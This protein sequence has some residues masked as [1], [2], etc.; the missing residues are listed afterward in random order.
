MLKK[1]QSLANFLKKAKLPLKNGEN[2]LNLKKNEKKR[3]LFR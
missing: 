1:L 3:E 2:S